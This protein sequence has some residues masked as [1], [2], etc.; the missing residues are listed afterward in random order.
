MSVQ[1][2]C[3]VGKPILSEF[4]DQGVYVSDEVTCEATREPLGFPAVCGLQESGTGRGGSLVTLGR[5]LAEP[6]L[7]SSL[8]S[9]PPPHLERLPLTRS[10][11]PSIFL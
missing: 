3:C 11:C 4:Q 1:L 10:S 6:G 2:T 5:A 7:Q 9:S 8:C